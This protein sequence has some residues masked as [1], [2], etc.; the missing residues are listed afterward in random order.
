MGIPSSLTIQGKRGGLDGVYSPDSCYSRATRYHS[1]VVYFILV[2]WPHGAISLS[3]VNKEVH[4]GLKRKSEFLPSQI[5][6]LK[7]LVGRNLL[8][9]FLLLLLLCYYSSYCGK[10][11]GYQQSEDPTKNKAQRVGTGEKMRWQ[12]NEHA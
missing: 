12:Q 10:I 4:A 1:T 6:L 11:F 8:F 3:R 7:S 2:Q 5:L 9:L